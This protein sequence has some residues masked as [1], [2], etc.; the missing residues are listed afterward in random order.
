MSQTT[1]V[2]LKQWYRRAVKEKASHM[3]VVCDTFNYDDY[4][5]MVKKDEDVKKAIADH[6]GNMQR[7]MEVYKMSLGQRAQMQAGRRVWNI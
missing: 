1:L 7:V 4:P 3:L 2:T 6:S 5:V